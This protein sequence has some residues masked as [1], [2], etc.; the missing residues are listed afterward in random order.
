MTTEIKDAIAKAKDLRLHREGPT[1]LDKIIEILNDEKNVRIVVNAIDFNKYD[2]KD[3]GALIIPYEL[4][5]DSDKNPTGIFIALNKKLDKKRQRFSLAHELGHLALDHIDLK[6]IS[7][8]NV[9]HHIHYDL[10][11]VCCRD[12]DS[13][14]EKRENAANAF[15]QE[16]LMPE[17]LIQ[18]L[19]KGKYFY[20]DLAQYFNV[21]ELAARARIKNLKDMA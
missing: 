4:N 12:G 9:S 15:A 20:S 13:M 8:L 14:I 2:L 1:N 21:S 5:G 10:N 3:A 7:L 6:K 11:E 16:L 19:T 17:D 18:S